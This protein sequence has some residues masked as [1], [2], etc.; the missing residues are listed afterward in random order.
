MTDTT[1]DDEYKKVSDGSEGIKVRKG[2]KKPEKETKPKNPYVSFRDGDKNETLDPYQVAIA[3]LQERIIYYDSKED[4]VYYYKNGI[5][6]EATPLIRGFAVRLMQRDYHVAVLKNIRDILK[7]LSQDVADNPLFQNNGLEKIEKFIEPEPHLVLFKDCIYDMDKEEF[8]P[9]KPDYVFRDGQRIEFNLKGEVSD[10]FEKILKK[11]KGGFLSKEHYDLFF[12]MLGY[13]F[14]RDYTTPCFLVIA[15]EGGNGKS[16]LF[17]IL[18]HLFDSSMETL[19]F[20]ALLNPERR[21][22][23]YNKFCNAVSE[24]PPDKLLV[25]DDFKALTSGDKLMT[26]KLYRTETVSQRF[27]T[28]Y[29]FFGNNVPEVKD[30]SY[31]F[32]RRVRFIELLDK[33]SGIEKDVIMKMLDKEEVKRWLFFESVKG[34]N[35]MKKDGF[36][37]IDG[38]EN[39]AKR[40]RMVSNPETY[41]L[42]HAVSYGDEDGFEIEKGVLYSR[43]QAYCKMKQLKEKSKIKFYDAV[44]EFFGDNVSEIENQTG[45]H[46]RL[47]K[48]IQLKDNWEEKI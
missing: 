41:F 26:R 8:L 31:G 36:T 15:G 30:N 20:L 45:K 2:A 5:Y 47:F 32:D 21:I 13:S 37:M 25:T 18:V 24:T 4:D 43:Y 46:K 11:G 40:Y 10:E 7:E 39:G 23:L 9:L 29:F 33:I 22:N 12:E 48:G 34:Y 17:E 19:P 42:S 1:S 35:R 6:T 27:Y 3:I 38:D 16:T 28:K 44:R 14:Y